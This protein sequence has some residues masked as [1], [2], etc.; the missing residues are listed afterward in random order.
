MLVINELVCKLTTKPWKGWTFFRDLEL[1]KPYKE[2]VWLN[3]TVVVTKDLQ[4][5]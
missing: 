5:R 3:Q 2:P 4:H 1:E